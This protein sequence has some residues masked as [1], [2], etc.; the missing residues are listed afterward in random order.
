MP[1]YSRP[2]YPADVQRRAAEQVL[3]QHQSIAQVA[4][5]FRC[6]KQSIQRWIDKHRTTLSNGSSLAHT[7]FLP[8]KVGN[9]L[10]L[11]HSPMIELTTKTG[12]TLRFPVSLPSEALCNI[13]Q[14][15]GE[16]C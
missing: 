13:R 12:L 9:D 5:Q 16:P 3:L 15:E 1:K 11:P 8:L 10:S 6:S 7:T 14:L 4:K 2:H